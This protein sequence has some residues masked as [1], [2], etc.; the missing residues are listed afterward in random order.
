MG[1]SQIISDIGPYKDIN[2][3][4]Y[5]LHLIAWLLVII[6]IQIKAQVNNKQIIY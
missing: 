6:F 4:S 1:T 5:N 2:I 3:P